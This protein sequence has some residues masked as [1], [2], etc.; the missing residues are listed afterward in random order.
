[1][2]AEAKWVEVLLNSLSLR[3]SRVCIW[4]AHL[5]CFLLFLPG[6]VQEAVCCPEPKPPSGTSLAIS[7]SGQLGF[8]APEGSLALSV[9]QVRQ[10]LGVLLSES[11][12][13]YK[14]AFFDSKQFFTWFTIASLSENP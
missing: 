1:L 8:R 11:Y 5:E 12:S 7:L 13:K 3:N 2:G 4:T 6:S 9:Y 14:P 10:S